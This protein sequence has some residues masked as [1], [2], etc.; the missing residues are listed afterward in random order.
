MVVGGYW[1]FY[2]IGRVEPLVNILDS[3][4][5]KFIWKNIV[6]KLAYQRLSY[7]ITGSSLTAKS[8][9]GVVN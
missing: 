4:V 7:R 5:K 8:L 9:E 1:L 6:T 3:N 2:L